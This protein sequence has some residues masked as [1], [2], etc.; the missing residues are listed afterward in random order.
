MNKP[1]YP[2]ELKI[3]IFSRKILRKIFL[4]INACFIGFWLGILKKQ[5]LH[6]IDKLYYDNTQQ[7]CDEE[8][9]RGGLWDWEK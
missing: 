5:H 1:N 7:Y 4:L 6:L 8:Y 3:Y 2:L 9:N